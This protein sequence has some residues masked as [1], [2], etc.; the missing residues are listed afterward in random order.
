LAFYGI[1]RIPG[2]STI[3]NLV[4]RITGFGVTQAMLGGKLPDIFSADR[5]DDNKRGP[6]T[7]LPPERPGESWAPHRCDINGSSVNCPSQRVGDVTGTSQRTLDYS[8]SVGDGIDRTRY[9][10]PYKINTVYWKR[11]GGMD[12]DLEKRQLD[13]VKA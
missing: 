11:Y 13:P 7:I 9:T 4:N 6:I 2:F 12:R 5:M 1:N 3:R 8:G 10:V